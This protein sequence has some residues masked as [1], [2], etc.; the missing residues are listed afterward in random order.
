MTGD[1]CVL[2]KIKCDLEKLCSRIELERPSI[3][4][5]LAQSTRSISTIE[6][7]TINVF[8][9][10]GKVNKY[11]SLSEIEMNIPKNCIFDVNNKSTQSYCNYSMFTI[12]SFL[13]ERN[14]NTPFIFIHITERD[15]NK[16]LDLF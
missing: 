15:I 2:D 9:K 5:G 10:N 13:L 4:I 1:V 14:I 11:C 12:K 16:L 8:H 7:K 6:K 3:I